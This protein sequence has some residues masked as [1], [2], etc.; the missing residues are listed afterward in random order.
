MNTYFFNNNTLLKTT[1]AATYEGNGSQRD[2]IQSDNK[3]KS[4]GGFG[5]DQHKFVLSSYINKKINAQHTLQTGIVAEN[6]SFKTK[7]SLL[8]YNAVANKQFWGYNN[9]FNGNT[10]LLCSIQNIKAAMA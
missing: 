4:I 7:D 5:Y 6:I 10:N 2:T 3:L 1:L 9:D 8:L